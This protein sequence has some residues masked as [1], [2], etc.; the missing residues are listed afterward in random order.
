MNAVREKVEPFGVNLSPTLQ[1]DSTTHIVGRTRNTPPILEGLVR[2]KYIVAESYIDALVAAMT[3]TASPGSTATQALKSPLEMD[4]DANL[5]DPMEHVPPPGREPLPRPAEFLRP[6]ARRANMFGGVSFIF[7]EDDQRAALRGP[8]EVGQGKTILYPDF[9]VGSTTAEH[10]SAFV[11]KTRNAADCHKVVVVRPPLND[12]PGPTLDWKRSFLQAVDLTL[13]QRSIVQNELLDAI[14]TCDVDAL[15]QP[16]QDMSGSRGA[17]TQRPSQ[18]SSVPPNTQGR[19]EQPQVPAEAILVETEAR[20]EI[21]EVVAVALKVEQSPSKPSKSQKFRFTQAKSRFKG[22]DDF[23]DGAVPAIAEAPDDSIME[24]PEVVPAEEPEPEPVQTTRRNKRPADLAMDALLPAAAAVKRRRVQSGQVQEDE[25]RQEVVEAKP[26]RVFRKKTIRATKDDN[27]DI[28][29]AARAMREHEQEQARLDEELNGQ[30]LE[31]EEVRRIREQ[32]VVGELPIRIPL[33]AENANARWDDQWNGRPNFKKFRRKGGDGAQPLRAHRVI[34]RLEE[35]KKR[36]LTLGAVRWAAAG[37]NLPDS[38][39]TARDDEDDSQV[40]RGSRVFTDLQ[41]HR[42]SNESQAVED[43][44]LVARSASGNGTASVASS[45]TRATKR[46]VVS[47]ISLP[48]KRAASRSQKAK[49]DDSSD[50]SVD[51][52]RFKFAKRP[53]AK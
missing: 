22:F 49:A 39:S 46:S 8:I 2:G 13:G 44:I 16:L 11:K 35:A 48:A 31:Q 5:P 36:D 51:D 23:D 9:S 18:A 34:V 40:R 25:P 10:I 26:S 42:T 1:P 28:M 32:I 12:E 15:C 24:E 53:R 4:F 30:P 7:Y 3:A 52:L 37:T 14:L 17:S 27:A 45:A 43:D 21:E 29:D 6:S 47:R 38:P 20:P 41:S 50:G 19:T 33:A